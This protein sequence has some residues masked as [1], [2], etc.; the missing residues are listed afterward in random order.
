MPSVPIPSPQSYY[1][2]MRNC[3]RTCGLL[4][5][6]SSK[7]RTLFGQ[8]AVSLDQ[9]DRKKEHRKKTNTAPERKTRVKRKARGQRS[10]ATN[11]TTASISTGSSRS[12]SHLTKDSSSPRPMC[13]FEEI[14]E[15]AARKVSSMRVEDEPVLPPLSRQNNV[16]EKRSRLMPAVSLDTTTIH[17]DQPVWDNPKLLEELFDTE[18]EFALDVTPPSL[19][20][21]SI[22]VEKVISEAT[23][24]KDYNPIDHDRKDEMISGWS[25][26]ENDYSNVD[27]TRVHK[28]Q[29]PTSV[30][31]PVR[32]R[33]VKGVTYEKS[34][35]L[36][37][38]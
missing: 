8:K 37:E 25:S 36:L 28:P 33:R 1:C 27:L 19:R 31:I 14:M 18:E 11:I 35:D 13:T 23:H 3:Q 7:K 32:K 38:N 22:I 29:T 30:V 12:G 16:F 17:F 21:D 9:D 26:D 34:L 10:G 2:R 15:R 24:A 20:E 4:H 6:D 5:R